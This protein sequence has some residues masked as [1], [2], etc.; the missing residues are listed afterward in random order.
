MLELLTNFY[1]EKFTNWHGIWGRILLIKK[2]IKSSSTALLQPRHRDSATTGNRR[3]KKSGDR[4]RE[5]GR[6]IRPETH[7]HRPDLSL[8]T[9]ARLDLSLSPVVSGSGSGAPDLSFPRLISLGSRWSG[10]GL[11]APGLSCPRR[12]SLSR[13]VRVWVDS[14]ISLLLVFEVWVGSTGLGRRQDLSV[15]GVRVQVGVGSAASPR[16][17]PPRE[18]TRSLFPSPVNSDVKFINRLIK[19]FN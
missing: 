10:T 1:K 3:Q 15:A 19:F 14:R 16:H 8:S 9:H 7:A 11:G 4:E 5:R 18:L 13:V 6:E 2:F 12:I 17:R